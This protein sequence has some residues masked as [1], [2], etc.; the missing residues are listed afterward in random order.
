MIVDFFKYIDEIKPTIIGGYNSAFF[1]WEWI[2]RRAEI[3]GLDIGDVAKTLNP[4]V[5]LRDPP[6]AFAR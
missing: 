2:I 6:V 3:L 4:N 5:R 1:D